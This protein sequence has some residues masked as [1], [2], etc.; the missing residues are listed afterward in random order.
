MIK[1]IESPIVEFLFCF[2]AIINANAAVSIVV[3]KL[4]IAIINVQVGSINMEKIPITSIDKSIIIAITEHRF[5]E[6]TPKIPNI[7]I[8]NKIA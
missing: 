1:A 2:F 6:Q 8:E 7:A 3:N 5:S 4:G